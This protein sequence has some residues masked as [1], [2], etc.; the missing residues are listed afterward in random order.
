MIELKNLNKIYEKRGAA[1]THAVCDVSLQLPERG[2]VAIFGRSGCGKTTLL[3]CVGGLDRATSGSVCFDGDEV[4]PN[5]STL[6]NRHIGYIFQN[7]NL[8]KSMTVYEN[9]ALSLRLCGLCDEQE[10]ERRVLAALES[11]DMAKY[12]RR[13]PDA[14]SGG[15]QQRV[16]IARAIVKNPDLILADEPTG[17]LDEQNTVMVMDLLKEIAKEKLVLL[18]T[19]EASLVDL[20]CDRVIEMADGRVVDERET[21]VTDGYHGKSDGEIYLGDLPMQSQK[22]G[23]SDVEYYGDPAELPSRIRFVSVGGTLYVQADTSLKL[24]FVDKGSEAHLHEGK[25]QERERRE[26]REISPTL[27]EGLPVGEA[28]RMY[29]L[30]A[31]IKS[32]FRAN[33]SKVRRGKKLLIA[34]LVCFPMVIALVLALFGT[35]FHQLLRIEDTYNPNTV[36]VQSDAITQ[37]Q[38]AALRQQGLVDNVA[39][40]RYNFSVYPQSL[41]TYFFSIGNFETFFEENAAYFY[42]EGLLL[43]SNLLTAESKMLCGTSVIEGEREMVISRGY[44]KLLLERVGVD[45]IKDYDDLL[46]TV[47]RHNAWGENVLPQSV[48]GITDESEAVIYVDP[49]TYAQ[50]VIEQIYSCE[51]GFFA[52]TAHAG[53]LG[54]EPARGEIYCVKGVNNKV[55]GVHESLKVGSVVNIGGMK[56]TVKDFVVQEP[57]EEGFALWV[58]ARYNANIYESLSAFSRW[59]W[60]F[61]ATDA[62]EWAEYGKGFGETHA[63]ALQEL[64]REYSS[65]LS[66]DREDFLEGAGAGATVVMHAE[67]LL[68][69]AQ[70]VP[71][72]QENTTFYNMYTD[73]ITYNTPY[74]ALHTEQTEALIAQLSATLDASDFTT[75]QQ[76]HEHERSYRVEELLVSCIVILAVSLVMSLCLYFIMRSSLMGEIREVG[77][78][79]AIGVSRRNLVFRYFVET[80]VLFALTIFVGFLLSS[81]ALLGISSMHQAMVE[82]LYYPWWMALALLAY[83][84]GVS[85]LCGLLPICSLLRRTPAEILSK[86]DI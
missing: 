6:R 73:W 31:A 70:T 43:P 71:T 84:V 46:Y 40:C 47:G 83:L 19:H 39:L 55:S 3:N 54:A 32:G 36:F 79:R 68:A 69:L 61:D 50:S 49:Y 1:R 34:S 53:I 57:D 35:V 17:N 13:M 44:A 76:I 2:I 33:F 45:F 65:S 22:L 58:Y 51:R 74:F 82:L 23:D 85:V 63:E 59:Q 14:L 38:L 64:E 37:E 77:I 72:G 9:V 4:T 20:Y 16:A 11:V 66:V 30:G 25:Y 42:A 27:R 41:S 15:Q 75:P 29:R 78:L 81:A 12:R 48:V 52:D 62:A 86:Y 7:Y 26:V 21:A 5:K 18:V 60:G 8:A 56:F 24:R 80:M 67:D 10:I 28:G